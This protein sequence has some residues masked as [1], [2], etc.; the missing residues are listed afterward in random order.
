MSDTIKDTYKKEIEQINPSA[1]FLTRLTDNLEQ[2]QAYRSRRKIIPLKII[3]S[4]AACIAAVL[5][6][7]LSF[8]SYS[9]HVPVSANTDSIQSQSKSGIEHKFDNFDTDTITSRP[10]NTSSLFNDDMTAEQC[11][12]LFLEKV[13]NGELSYIKISDSNVFTSAPDDSGQRDLLLDLL[14]SGKSADSIPDGEKTYYMAVFSDGQ[15]VKLIVTDGK[16][17]EFSGTNKYLYAE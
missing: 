13:D 4:A 12:E 6:G 9:N 5:C 14:S 8:M 3:I 1:E 2:E 15:I 11:A 7:A 17:I 16:Y 10:I